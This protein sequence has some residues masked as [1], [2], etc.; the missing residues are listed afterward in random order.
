MRW[1]W[2]SSPT[3]DDRDDK[4]TSVSWTNALNATDW[5]HYTDPQTVIPTVVLTGSALFLTRL[6][7]SYLRRIPQ[8]AS[9]QPAFWRKRSLFG[10]V[11]SVGDGDNF[12]LFHTPGGRLAGWDWMPGRRIPVKREDLK[13]RTVRSC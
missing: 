11:T 10:E 2:Q 13:D 5:K 3:S 1:P 12:R 7:R 8:A 4:G 9:I 6:Y